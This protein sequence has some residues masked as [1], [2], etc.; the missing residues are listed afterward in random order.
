MRG[1]ASRSKHAFIS[2]SSIFGDKK[3]SGFRLFASH[4]GQRK[5]CDKAVCPITGKLHSDQKSDWTA[6]ADDSFV[7][8]TDIHHWNLNHLFLFLSINESLLNSF[9]TYQIHLC[10][11]TIL[12]LGDDNT[13]FGMNS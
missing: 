5:Y 11:E 8:L 2:N 13:L 9:F 7:L 6:D 1:P 4:I 12:A 10:L 3:Y